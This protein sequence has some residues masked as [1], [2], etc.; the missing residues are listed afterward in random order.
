MTWVGIDVGDRAKGF[1]VAVVDD[2]SVTLRKVV[3]PGAVAEVTRHVVGCAP[4]SVGIDA[5]AAWAPPGERSRP[6]ERAFAAAGICGIRFTPDAATAA[7][8]PDR[9]YGW[10]E[11]G[12]EL[13]GALTAA[14]VVACDEVF[15]T[16]SCTRWIGA[17]AGRSRAAW[18]R[19]GLARVADHLDGME[20]AT[21]Q[22]LRDAVA[23][24]LTARSSDFGTVDRFGRIVVPQGPTTRN[25]IDG[26]PA[27]D[28]VAVGDLASSRH[29]LQG[30][31]RV[32]A[33]RVTGAPAGESPVSTCR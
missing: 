28:D 32:D 13:W 14:G 11:H 33:A 30:E 29:P 15:P 17:R 24:A 19:A 21:S 31:H 16:A 20:T 2:T 23:A 26:V 7:A 8:R 25:G 18:T 12:L 5:P 10:V 3:G 1:H 6:D 27:Q 4:R 22:D 9:F